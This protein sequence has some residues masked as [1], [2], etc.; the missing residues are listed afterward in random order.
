MIPV[1][2]TAKNERKSLPQLLTSL[3]AAK[4]FAEL[5]GPHRFELTLVLNDNTDNTLDLIDL[6]DLKIMETTGGLIEAQ[7]AFVLTHPAPYH[8]FS[9]ADI[10]VPKDA[11][12]RISEAME[13]QLTRIAYLEKT[14]VLP[15]SSSH[16]ARSLYLYNLNNGYQSER[17]YLNG[18]FFAIKEWDIPLSPAFDARKNNPFLALEQGIR[19]DDIYLSRKVLHEDGRSAIVL[20]DSALKYRAPESLRGMY[21]KYQR[22]VLEI[23]RLNVFFPET[24]PTHVNFGKRKFLPKKLSF[25]PHL[26]KLYYLYFLA[27]LQ[28]CKV[29]YH[30]EKFFYTKRRSGSCPTWRPVEETKEAYEG[31]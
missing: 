16:L 5:N 29:W 17:N 6:C 14:P 19:C 25:R 28:L 10:I 26:E 11:L 1:C 3:R 8:I 27:A 30:L 13:N 24:I 23:E 2:V 15:K 18:Q 9:D 7:R 21:R 4:K 12:L 31:L 20:I 22:M